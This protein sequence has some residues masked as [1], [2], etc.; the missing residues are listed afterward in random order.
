MSLLVPA[1]KLYSREFKILL[2]VCSWTNWNFLIKDILCHFIFLKVSIFLIS[3]KIAGYHV[4]GPIRKH[5]KVVSAA[6]LSFF[7]PMIA[8]I[9]LN[10]MKPITLDIRKKTNTQVSY[11]SQ[12]EFGKLST[13]IGKNS[14]KFSEN[15]LDII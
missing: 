12:Q 1:T 9:D 8:L 3:L 6:L 7:L 5:S 13:F 2:Y 15:F 11:P 4:W 10:T 14:N